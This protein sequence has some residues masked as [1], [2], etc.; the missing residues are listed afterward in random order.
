MNYL[1]RKNFDNYVLLIITGLTVIIVIFDIQPVRPVLGVL[2]VLVIPGY[3][4]ANMLV[5]KLAFKWITSNKS[6]IMKAIIKI[7]EIGVGITL[8]L[9]INPI[10]GFLLGA[11]GLFTLIPITLSLSFI[12]IIFTVTDIF[13]RNKHYTN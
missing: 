3:A 12:T 8:S 2:F 9:A 13:I 5:D 6:L 1:T 10:I 11:F 7:F 4:F